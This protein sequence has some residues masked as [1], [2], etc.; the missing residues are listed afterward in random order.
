MKRPLSIAFLALL[1]AGLVA[2]S[3]E[4]DEPEPLILGSGEHTFEW[5]RDWAKL[6]DGGP[7]GYTHGC[8]LVDSQG[9]VYVN[10][11]T[12]EAVKVFDSEGNYLTGWGKELAGGLHGMTVVAEEGEEFLYM[13]HIGRGELIKATLD[14]EILWT[15]GYPEE[16]GLYPDGKRYHPT[17]VA[18]APNGDIY[19]AD[20]Y[21]RSW[22][23][24]YSKDREYLSSFGGPGQ[25]PGKL[26]TPHGIWIK[27]HQ[28]RHVVIVAD[29]GNRR[30]QVFDLEGKLLPGTV[31]GLLKPCHLHVRDGEMVVPEIEGRVTILDDKGEV[32]VHLGENADPARRDR[33]DVP[34]EEWE[35]G[36]FIS[37][38]CACFDAEGNVYVVDWLDAG[39]LTKL[40]RIR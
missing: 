9:R 27:E 26:A 2:S 20:G 7:L 8:V 5:V 16:S 10:T 19:V 6:P 18:V 31:D 33:K 13:T 32:L 4:P 23:H 30:L 3:Q 29:R 21:G 25:E 12:E 39:R 15:V 35:D 38:H 37:P 17:S 28:G 36:V 11:D 40:K 1:A 34:P 22:I 24:R 14:G